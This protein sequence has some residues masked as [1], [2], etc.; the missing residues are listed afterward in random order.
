MNQHR[1]CSSAALPNHVCV[2]LWALSCPALGLSQPAA[3]TAGETRIQFID[4]RR[5]EGD[6]PRDRSSPRPAPSENRLSLNESTKKGSAPGISTAGFNDGAHHWRRIRDSSR[7]IQPLP[8][9]A[10]YAPDQVEE[11]VGNILLFQRANGGWPK[12]YDYLAALTPEQVAAVRATHDRADTSFDNHNTHSQVDYLARAYAAY[13]NDSWRAAC[14]RG[15]DFLL[16]AQLT[17]GGFPQRYP[18]PKSYSAHI[19]FNDGVMIGILNVLKDAAD[20]APHWQW[21]D[22]DRRERARQAVG[23]AIDCILDCQIKTPAGRTGWCQQHDEKTFE[24]ASARTF[25]LASCCP[26]DTTEIVRFLMRLDSP[27]ER[28][29]NAVDTAVA[30]LRKTQLAGIRVQRVPAKSETFER[31]TAD[32]DTVVV[33]DPNAPP[34]W[35]RHYEI[36]SDRPLFASRDAVKRYAL[37]E[38]D[39][40]RRTGTPWYGNWPMQLIQVEYPRWR[41]KHRAANGTEP[42]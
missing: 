15:F 9:Q 41:E 5:P 29:V 28:V 6:R 14:L 34:L 36:G 37:A 17:S 27:D 42:K 2:V 7:F 19:T 24:A 18:N 38:I 21:L 13:G 12:D 25:E 26:Q 33:A 32:F 20:G 10:S 3:T 22:G 8:D 23:R 35:A 30:W 31:H 11:I 40:E 16:A 1:R 39:R 4:E